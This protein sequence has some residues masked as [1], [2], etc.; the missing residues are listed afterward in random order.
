MFDRGKFYL[1]GTL[2][3]LKLAI[4]DIELTVVEMT[5]FYWVTY[6]LE[7]VQ[8]LGVFLLRCSLTCI[9]EPFYYLI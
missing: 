4:V 1:N 8:F 6:L 7:F 9:I 5:L 2:Y 3:L